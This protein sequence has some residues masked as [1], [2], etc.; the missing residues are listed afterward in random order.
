M[1]QQ[2]FCLAFFAWL[3][4]KCG[5]PPEALKALSPVLAP[6]LTENPVPGC[7]CPI[8]DRSSAGLWF[9]HCSSL[10]YCSRHG[11]PLWISFLNILS[12]IATCLGPRESEISIP[13]RLGVLYGLFMLFFLQGVLLERIWSAEM[14]VMDVGSAPC[15][16]RGKML[17]KMSSP[18]QSKVTCLLKCDH[19]CFM[20]MSEAKAQF[21]PDLEQYDSWGFFLQTL[22]DINLL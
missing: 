16:V 10:W 13:S 22:Q 3:W 18:C 9:H 2:S 17:G 5:S 4:G 8:L 15:W 6:I 11:D 12:I 21:K 20:R 7:R 14:C 1:G 19:F